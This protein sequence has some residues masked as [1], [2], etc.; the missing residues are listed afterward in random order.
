MI[1]SKNVVLLIIGCLTVANS[2]YSLKLS[3]NDITVLVDETKTFNLLLNGF[4]DG[5]VNVTFV[6]AHEGLAVLNPTEFVINKETQQTA[7]ES[8]LVEVAGKKAGRLE[9]KTE[10][11]GIYDDTN[12]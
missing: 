8:F 5:D 9:V 7:D 4:V 2:E 10:V 3:T 12:K 6:E 1:V 11:N